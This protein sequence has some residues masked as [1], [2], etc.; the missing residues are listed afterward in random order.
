MWQGSWYPKTTT[1]VAS[2]I[3]IIYVIIMKKFEVIRELPKCARET[4]SEQMLL[5]KMVLIDLLHA[6]FATNLQFVKNE[7]SA[8]C[9]KVQ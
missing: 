1:T 3:T 9:S 7:I 2:K 5:E 8:K 6:W 4:R